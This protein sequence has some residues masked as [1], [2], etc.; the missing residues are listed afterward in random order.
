VSTQTESRGR[1]ATN[2]RWQTVWMPRGPS[3]VV[4]A[5]VAVNVGYRWLISLPGYFWQDDY[6]ITAWAEQNPLDSWYLFLPFSDHFQ[7]LG[8]AI[9][10][11]CQRLFPGSY[12]AG[13]A[14]TA[15]V[16][17]AS[18]WVFYR[19][20]VRL[21]GWRSQFYVVILLW[22]FSIFTVQSYLWYAASLYLAP[23]L[24]LVP[25]ALWAAVACLDDPRAWRLGLVFLTATCA[26][27]AHTF[28]AIVPVLTAAMI[29][30]MRLGSPVSTSW[31]RSLMRQWL[32][33]AVQAIPVA[34]VAVFYLLRTS[35]GRGVAL[36]LPR[37][38]LDH[39]PWVGGWAVALQRLPFTGVPTPHA[40]R[41]FARRAVPCRTCNPRQD[42]ATC[43]HALGID[44][45]GG[46]RTTGECDTRPWRG[47]YVAGHQVCGAG[48]HSTST[49][50]QLLHGFAL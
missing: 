28:G 21:Y 33:I 20:L 39:H 19:L 14:W 24:L 37:V 30:A 35:S 32:L 23:Y 48:T 6:Y 47:R 38:R 41:G 36:C 40:P 29:V 22:G 27:L 4:A 5:L 2:S 13:M 7:P 9:A 46:Q 17:A 16:Y 34:T 26:V 45:R 10:W 43:L 44:D 12:S 1:V 31:W 15:F 3:L 18:I 8:F 50:N 11:V 49:G 42:Q 25:L